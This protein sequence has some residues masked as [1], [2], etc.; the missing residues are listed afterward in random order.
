MALL[1]KDLEITYVRAGGP[2][3]QHRNKKATGVRI[4][5]I[6]SGLVATATERRERARNHDLALERLEARLAARARRPKPRKKTR[7]TRASVEGRLQAKARRARV[8]RERRAPG[9]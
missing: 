4:V 1:R 8:K 9:D 6:P 3:G 5:H 2:G 7:P